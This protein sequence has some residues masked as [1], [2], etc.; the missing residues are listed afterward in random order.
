VG[1]TDVTSKPLQRQLCRDI[2]VELGMGLL[3]LVHFMV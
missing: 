2:L 3:T 1:F